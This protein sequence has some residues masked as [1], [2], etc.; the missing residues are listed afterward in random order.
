MRNSKFAYEKIS[1][2]GKSAVTTEDGWC[3]YATGNGFIGLGNAYLPTLTI[4]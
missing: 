4:Y 2:Y 1:A 3:S